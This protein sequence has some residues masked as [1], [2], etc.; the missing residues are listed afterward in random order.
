MTSPTFCG[1]AP[2]PPVN[3]ANSPLAPS[4]IAGKREGMIAVNSA[5]INASRIHGLTGRVILINDVRD[6]IG[7]ILL[8]LCKGWNAIVLFHIAWT[9]IICSECQRPASELLIQT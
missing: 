9:C 1:C 7:Y 2:A 5:P 8:R 3:L 4:A 6:D